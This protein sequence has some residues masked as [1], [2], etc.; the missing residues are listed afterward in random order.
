MIEKFLPYLGPLLGVIVGAFLNHFLDSKKTTLIKEND[1]RITAFYELSGIKITITQQYYSCYEAEINHEMH[2]YNW[3]LEG[4]RADSLDKEQTIFWMNKTNERNEQLSNSL[5]QLYEKLGS[6]R[7]AYKKNKDV[8]I[9]IDQF[10][11]K[12]LYFDPVIDIQ[13]R[14]IQEIK[15]WGQVTLQAIKNK[16]NERYWN[17]L[18]ELLASMKKNLV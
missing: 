15:Q 11:E 7:I 14:N 3:Q 9:L 12:P 5:R 17:P 18:D 8:C 6:A 10:S 1:R 13:G 4:L 16:V 2:K